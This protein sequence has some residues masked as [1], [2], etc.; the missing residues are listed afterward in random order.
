MLNK[1]IMPWKETTKMD[2]RYQFA[3]EALQPAV[4]M[5]ELC[6]A[7][8]ISKP[9]G[10]KW[11][12]RFVAEGMQGLH[13]LSR[14]PHGSANELPERVICALIKLKHHHPSWG[15]YK[16]RELYARRHGEAQ[17]P[18]DSSV[19]RVLER[20]GLVT[21]RRRRSSHQSGRLHSTSTVQAS[22]C[23][24]VWTVDFKGWWHTVDGNRCE[25]LTVR[26]EWSRYVLEVR[27]LIPANTEQVRK[28]FEK[29]FATHGLPDCIRSDNG[30]PFASSNAVLG[31]SKLAAWWLALGINLE[32][33]RP[34]KPQ[35]NGAHERMHRDIKHELQKHAQGDIAAQQAAFELWR[36][37][38]NEE[39]PHEALGMRTPSEIYHPSA[40]PWKCTPTD[41]SYDMM[42]RRVVKNGR[43]KLDGQQIHISTA[44][45][46]WSVGLKPVDKERLGVYFAN[47]KIGEIDLTTAASGPN[48]K[49]PAVQTA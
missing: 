23:N 2:Q 3:L 45:A 5:S 10:Y 38:F 37:T 47:L 12:R 33:G 41:I 4:N 30:S 7:Y 8:G 24:E 32:R 22:A 16:I 18:S 19:K 13:D 39:R 31:L 28:S 9:T 44:L 26:D 35:D 27:V 14:R 48:E 40:K 21:K 1:G 46:G 42:T 6:Q 25:P 20:A 29:L 34:E 36:K 15:P 43:I 49:T 11:K 17:T